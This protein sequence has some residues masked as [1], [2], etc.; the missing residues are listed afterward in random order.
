[1]V[2]TI[3]ALKCD[4]IAVH[5]PF[6]EPV[7]VI[8]PRELREEYVAWAAEGCRLYLKAVAIGTEKG[9]LV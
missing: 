9:I 7:Y 3:N 2:E 1:M 4:Y 6:R 8:V 5:L